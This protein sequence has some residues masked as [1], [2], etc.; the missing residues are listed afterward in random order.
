MK[1]IEFFKKPRNLYLSIVT[2]LI[3]VF[4]L[5][6]ITF[7]YYIEDSSDS[8]QVMKVKTIN[9]VIQTDDLESDEITLLP[10]ETKVIKIKVISNNDYP[11]D[12][13]LYY[14]GEDVAVTSDKEIKNTIDTKES[15]DYELTFINNKEE[16]NIVKLGIANG[17]LGATIEI[18][19]NEIK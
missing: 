2:M 10:G 11:N 6:S 7:S 19:G 13:K 18:T 12:Y 1:I 9:T 4:G 17:Y 14:V 8:N 5:S 15:L 16:V 3:V